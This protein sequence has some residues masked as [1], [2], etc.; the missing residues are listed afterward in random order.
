VSIPLIETVPSLRTY[1]GVKHVDVSDEE[2]LAIVNPKILPEE[3]RRLT[4]LVSI[5]NVVKA[6]KDIALAYNHLSGELLLVRRTQL[7]SPE[8][9]WLAF[10]SNKRLIGTTS[11]L[12]NLRTSNE[13]VKKALAI[14]LNSTITLLQLIAFVAETRGAWV[15][16]HGSQVW[17]HIHVPN[18][19]NF[20]KKK[21]AKVNAIWGRIRKLDVKP[22]YQRIRERDR[23]QRQIDEIALEMV[24]LDS[25]KSRLDELYEAV[26][27]ELET[28]H[29]ILETSRKMSA[30]RRK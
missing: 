17:A 22:L 14:Y 30:S 27:E 18:V 25:W 8:L 12:L 23:T 21:R 26:A 9:Y 1:S 28:M 7:S 10:Y 11:A 3:V 29:K 19:D 15:T 2:E 6:A 4:S 16:L 24:G 13:N 20:D 5:H